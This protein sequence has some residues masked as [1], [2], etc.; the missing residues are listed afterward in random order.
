MAYDEVQLGIEYDGP[1]HWTDPAV[2]Q[3]DIDRQ[4]NLAE[5]GWLI[6]RV[7]R[8]PVALPARRLRG[9]GAKR[10]ALTRFLFV[11]S[12]DGFRPI[13]VVRSSQTA[14]VLE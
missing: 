8:G 1:Q 9:T 13:R 10:V 4:F 11:E 14:S 6:I 7:S 12:D 5:L 2:R 3:R